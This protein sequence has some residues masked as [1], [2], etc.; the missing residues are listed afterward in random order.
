MGAGIET[1][2][3]LKTQLSALSAV[4]IRKY[5]TCSL[6]E[7]LNDLELQ[8]AKLKILPMC[9]FPTRIYLDTSL[10]A[11]A[12]VY[13]LMNINT[14]YSKNMSEEITKRYMIDFLKSI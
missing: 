4:T 9:L 1:I 2:W 7:I 5:S 10:P 14:W 3:L 12:L 11:K 8:M 6:I 13:R